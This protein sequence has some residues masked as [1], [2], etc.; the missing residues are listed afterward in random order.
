MYKRAWTYFKQQRYHT[1]VEWF[2]QLLHYA[3]EQEAKTGDPGAD[4]RAEA[5][6]YIAGSLTY[7][8]FDGPPPEDPYIPRN[9]VLDVETDPV[10]AEDK[11]HIAIDRVQDPTLI[12]QDKKWSV[13]I[14]KALAQEFIEITQNRNAIATLELTLKKFPMDRDA[15]K[16]QNKIAEL[17]DQLFRLAPE[18]SAV[19][20]EYA[21]KALD[22]RTKLASYV[23]ATPWTEANKD[24][25]EA[26]AEAEQLVRQGLQRA[27]ADH[28]NFARSYYTKAG[29]VQDE[30]EQRGLL[31][32]S[33]AEYRLAEIGWAA[34]ISQDP[35][36]SDSYESRF[37]LA[38]A[39]F[40]IVVLQVTLGRSP[41]AVEISGAEEA[42]IDVRDSNDDDKYLQP[43]AYYLVTIADKVLEDRYRQYKE[44]NGAQGLEKREE[45]KFEGEGEARKVVALALPEE[46]N[47]AIRSR[48]EYNDRV[49]PERDPQKNGMLY[50]FQAADFYFVYGQLEEARKR[51]EPLM[52]ENCGKNEWGYKAWEKLISISNFQNDAERSRKLA[53]GK[54]CAFDE[55]TR[56][57]EEAIRTPVRQGVAY[58]DARKLYEEAEKMPEGPERAKKWREAAAAYKVALDAA[59]DRDEAPEAAMN[60]AYAYKQ[61]GEYDKAI[62]MYEL[63]ISRYG[64]KQKLEALKNGDP[65]A[66]PPV[67]ADP[68]K[69]ESRVKFL[70]LAYD[71]LA[72]AYV[73]FF[74]YP[75]A[76]ETF[77]TVS[78]TDSFSQEQRREAAQQALSLYASLNDTKGMTRSRA[79]LNGLG[80]SPKQ[81]AEADFV[82]ASASLKQWDQFS[83]D[84]GANATARQRAESQMRTYYEA[85]LKNDGANEY[86]VEAAYW[87]AKMKRAAKDPAEDQWWKRTMEAFDRFK[88]TAPKNPDGTSSALGSRQ[89]G[90][91]AE[92]AFV[93]LDAQVRKDFDYE[94]GHHR[95]KGTPTEVLTAYQKG[96]QEAKT[97]Y[98]K[99]QVVI[100]GYAAPEWATAAIA[101]QGTLYDSLRTGLYNVRPPELKMFDAKTEAV[102]KKAEESDNPDLQEKADAVRMSVETAWRDKRDQELNSADEIVVD[103]YATSI[104]LARRYN[105][106]NPAVVK[107][108]QRLAFFTDVMG[109]AKLKQYTAR[110]PDLQYTEGMFLR[111][112]PGLVTAPSP[113]GMGT[114]V[115][116]APR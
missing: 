25:P 8:D 2:T 40:W 38:D 43:S 104:V 67:A 92:A 68:A 88:A 56:A 103:R 35:T 9:D 84:T 62:E 115:P 78:E 91:G 75:K 42:A 13:E 63:F 31:E 108:I 73:L 85:N 36:A 95:F 116:A 27:A 19:R 113:V 21:A 105:V 32:K 114:P 59:P 47:H 61:V 55:D 53:E 29:Q 69:Y 37:W 1:A 93:L 49:I 90:F 50:S 83:P 80:A 87:N 41:S 96:A 14:Y 4:F 24:D 6:T 57:A 98:D 34:Y 97:W 64:N 12:P 22:A 66:T 5:Y 79:Q 82:I 52:N 11:M 86:V 46:A 72:N 100:D 101:R 51:Y 18:G 15:P 71:A 70:K 16:M 26:L 30:S 10:V 65:N 7:V 77:R 33:V 107:A 17:Y 94:T 39:R 60:G 76:A 44:S 109:E 102:L 81:L 23:G 110:V 112:R 3:D 54:S 99:L 28:T 111:I 48:D 89:A 20:D 74:D 58:L 106:S 45:V